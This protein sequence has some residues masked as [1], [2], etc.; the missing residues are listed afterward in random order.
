MIFDPRGITTL[1]SDFTSSCDFAITWSPGRFLRAYRL[2]S[3]EGHV[4][5]RLASTGFPATS[6]SR[7]SAGG[8]IMT[9]SSTTSSFVGP[10]SST[11]FA[12]STFSIWRSGCRRD[13]AARPCDLPFLLSPEAW[14]LFWSYIQKLPKRIS[15][16][17][18]TTPANALGSW[19]AS[20][21]ATTRGLGSKR[22]TSI[23]A[24]RLS[25]L[26]PLQRPVPHLAVR[27]SAIGEISSESSWQHRGFAGSPNITSFLSHKL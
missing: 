6:I 13:T 27:H 5:C 20:S 17:I 15:G 22:C 23:L 24:R 4:L 9:H 18:G 8:P 7:R 26:P 10:D 3:R 16:A 1:P 25:S 2:A 19:D 14:I 11:C 21:T 12:A